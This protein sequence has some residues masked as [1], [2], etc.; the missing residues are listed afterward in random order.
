MSSPSDALSTRESLYTYYKETLTELR[1]K[2]LS[3]F[4][5]YARDLKLSYEQV[6][7]EIDDDEWRPNAYARRLDDKSYRIGITRGL[8]ERL[9]YLVN[10]LV[11]SPPDRSTLYISGCDYAWKDPDVS[12]YDYRDDSDLVLTEPRLRPLLAAY[13][14]AATYERDFDL[15]WG[16]SWPAAQVQNRTSALR[17][18]WVINFVVFHEMSHI[19]LRHL[20]KSKSAHNLAVISETT[21]TAEVPLER[22]RLMEG[23][24]DFQATTMLVYTLPGLREAARGDPVD[25][26]MQRFMWTFAFL[27][28]G[29]FAFWGK[30]RKSLTLQDNF[31][32]PHPEFR[33]LL[34]LET[35]DN[36]L[37]GNPAARQAW[38]TSAQEANHD[39]QN[40]YHSIGAPGVADTVLNEFAGVKEE[41][42]RAW[43]A[44]F[45]RKYREYYASLSEFSQYMNSTW[46]R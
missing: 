38:H 41:T 1:P 2:Y 12:L 6:L 31:L 17:F 27:M 28:F 33:K 13:N 15:S 19:L 7:L 22:R 3:T 29:L 32:H 30:T 25:T 14:D 37:R 46:S 40:A 21:S 39:I 45:H 23:Q 16:V 42:I 10:L 36:T 9:I 34:F 44:K 8:F 11:R 24:A 5:T 35:V 18:Y 43:Q 26:T 20:E 4:G